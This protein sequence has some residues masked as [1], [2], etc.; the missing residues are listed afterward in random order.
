MNS[1]R[2]TVVQVAE[3]PGQTRQQM[4]ALYFRYYDGSDEY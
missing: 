3:L 2:S 1:Y 4:A